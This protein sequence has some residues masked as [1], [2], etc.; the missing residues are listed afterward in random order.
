MPSG[1]SWLR[2]FRLLSQ[3]GRPRRQN[4]RAI[5][6]AMLYVLRGGLSWRLLPHDVPKG[7]TAYDYCWKWRRAGP[8]EEI[9]GRLRQRVRTA[10]GGQAQPTAAIL[11]SQTGKTTHSGGP[12]GDD[13]GQKGKGRKRHLLV[14]TLGLSELSK[15]LL[16]ILCLC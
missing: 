5:V 13:G 2:C 8:W 4:R 12:R 7:K 6:K 1:R 10:A 15:V 16:Q 3:G 9:N 14:D 11:D